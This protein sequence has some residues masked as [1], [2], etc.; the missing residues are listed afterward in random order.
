[1]SARVPRGTCA[2]FLDLAALAAIRSAVR[3]WDVSARGTAR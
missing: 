2:D 3:V 1:M